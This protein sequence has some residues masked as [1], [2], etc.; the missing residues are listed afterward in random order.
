M[1]ARININVAKKARVAKTSIAKKAGLLV[2]GGTLA[3]SG[4][5]AK[6]ERK[7]NERITKTK[8]KIERVQ[9]VDKKYNKK[10]IKK[11]KINKLLLS[12]HINQFLTDYPNS[13]I[14]VGSEVCAPCLQS[15]KIINN[16]LDLIKNQKIKNTH[17]NNLYF[18]EANFNEFIEYN[19][20]KRDLPN[21]L[22][23]IPAILYY[24]NGKLVRVNYGYSNGGQFIEQLN[25][26]ILD[27]YF[28]RQR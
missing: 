3:F 11:L 1:K 28:N 7:V 21:S 6:A 19:L 9:L 10:N 2:L 15:K 27:I 23:G 18:G 26:N 24:R 8:P 5:Q 13:I 25:K 20:M 17:T 16:W 14:V 4:L 22:K 12:D